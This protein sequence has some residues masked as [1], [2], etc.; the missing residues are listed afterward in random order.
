MANSTFRFELF[1]PMKRDKDGNYKSH[2]TKDGKYPIRLIY[3]VN[4]V[5]KFI[6][7]GQTLF[8]DSWDK[9]NQQ[10]IYL[11]KRTAKKL[12]PN[13]DYDLLPLAKDVDEI[14]NRLIGI[15]SD[16]KAIEKRFELDKVQYSAEMVINAYNEQRLPET[17][18]SDHKNSIID[19][20]DRY[21]EDN[22]NAKRNKTICNYVN[23]KFHLSEFNK[24]LTF[25]DLTIACLKSFQS[26]LLDKQG[27]S[28]ATIVKLF[29]ILK[30]ALKSARIDYKISVNQEYLDFVPS[31]K[32]D[33]EIEVIA[34][35]ETELQSIVNLELGDRKKFVLMEKSLKGKPIQIKLSYKALDKIRDVFLFSCATGLR[36]SDIKDLKREHIHGMTIKKI[37][38]K[39]GQSLQ[40]PLNELS[41]S[42]LERYKEMY[43]PLPVISGQKSNEYL[44]ELGK[45]AGID[46]QIEKVRNYGAQ[47]ERKTVPKY[48]LMTMHVGRKTFTT[49][50]LEKGVASQE[51]MTLT[52]HTTYK[53]FARYVKVTDERKRDAMVKA[54]G[55][56]QNL[57]V[58][59]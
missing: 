27:L 19:F 20:L 32:R 1:R 42:I 23:I 50:L 29:S 48:E 56:P 37:C 22:R 30:T 54:F 9:K 44:K 13:V 28:S 14:N 58:A 31:V 8:P 40:I 18:K 5:R 39:T 34:L 35:T 41:F 24:K 16:I 3:Q 7:V 55:K 2:V 12:M 47:M 17:K 38:V 52:G 51:V 11:D 36:F 49:F 46:S 57:K 33:R 15:I 21:I 4:S 6:P 59:K 26:F 25:D 45:L 10:A 43:K 53:S